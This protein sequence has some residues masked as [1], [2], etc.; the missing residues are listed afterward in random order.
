M[1]SVFRRESVTRFEKARDPVSLSSMKEKERRRRGGSMPTQKQGN[2]CHRKPRTVP[3]KKPIKSNER[4]R[5]SI[6]HRSKIY[7]AWR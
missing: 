1:E 2:P 5:G 6:Y 7:V 3:L 4:A